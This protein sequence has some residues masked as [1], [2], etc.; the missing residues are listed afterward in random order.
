MMGCL[1]F[2]IAFS[3]HIGLAG[4][5]N[6]VHPSVRCAKDWFI[7]GAYLNSEN[8][9]S[10]YVGARYEWN[11]AW[12]EG[13]IVGGYPYVDVVPYGRVGYSITDTVSLFTAPAYE[14]PGTLGVAV[15][16]EFT[17]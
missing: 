8:T 9:I 10:P 15:G 3:Y 6:E 1:S 16:I 5:Y 14:V 11:D 2:A 13:G 4:E 17:F 12:I 7:A